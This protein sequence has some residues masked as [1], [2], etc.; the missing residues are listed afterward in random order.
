MAS[1]LAL[2][3]IDTASRQRCARFLERVERVLDR[4]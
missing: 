4:F 3:N 2:Y 1:F